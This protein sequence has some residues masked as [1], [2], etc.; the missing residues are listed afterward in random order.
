[1]HP[2]LLETGWLTVYSYGAFLG[3][4]FLVGALAFRAELSRRGEDPAAAPL[5]LL[6]GVSAGLFGGRLFAALEQPAFWSAPARVFVHQAGLAYLGGLVCAVPVIGL[7]L[8][9]L[10]IRFGVAADAAIPGLLF[11]YVSARIG[12]LLA[13]DGCY[14][15]PTALPWGMTFPHGLV[16]T[17]AAQNALLRGRF[18]ELF[19]GV[20]V[21]ADI[22]VHP[23]PI[24]EAVLAFAI[25]T[26]LVALRRTAAPPGWLFALGL[27]LASV[28]RL[29]VE[30]LRLN[31]AWA[32]GLTQAQVLSLGLLALAVPTLV[33]PH[34]TRLRARPAPR[35]CPKEA[36]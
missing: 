14:G 15:V 31:D 33:R 1:M 30:L 7:A 26:L 34:A 16:P 24:Y 28:A 5:A 2:I 27:A 21:P 12:C 17:L 20:P 11:G 23:T 36:Q 22:A 3:L 13:A 9:R 35:T 10:G 29:G 18:E 4:A 6:L 19:P 32:F 25:G 8:S